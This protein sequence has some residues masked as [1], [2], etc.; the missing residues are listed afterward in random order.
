M[1]LILAG[2]PFT[3]YDA[4]RLGAL[5]GGIILATLA[6]WT[7]A[8]WLRGRTRRRATPDLMA[9]TLDDLRRMHKSG[10]FSDEEL[11]RLK[12][13]IIDEMKGGSKARGAAGD[14]EAR[15]SE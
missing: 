7:L 4:L 15:S 1:V 5:C 9:W 3:M 8:L 13:S 11:A 2:Q 12:Q 10:L 14:A 6:I